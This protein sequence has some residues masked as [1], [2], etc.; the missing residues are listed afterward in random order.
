MKK[1]TTMLTNTARL[2]DAT[3]KGLQANAADLTTLK[4]NVLDWSDEARDIADDFAL[5][6]RMTGDVIEAG[7]V[8]GED[9][10]LI[11]QFS[12]AD[13]GRISQMITKM[14]GIDYDRLAGDGVLPRTHPQDKAS[15]GGSDNEVLEFFM[16]MRTHP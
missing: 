7:A 9:R 16:Q 14:R 6:A 10:I 12:S 11:D 15:L 13:I 4:G 8:L 3:I 1:V 5:D 2:V